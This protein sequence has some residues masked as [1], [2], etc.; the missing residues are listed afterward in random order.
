MPVDFFGS[1]LV[2]IWTKSQASFA[3][4]TTLMESRPGRGM[5]RRWTLLQLSHSHELVLYAV[6][7]GWQIGID[8]ERIQADLASEQ[9]A[10][11]FFSPREVATL[12]ALP[13]DL[14][15]E[16][17]F[18]C[19][20]RKEAYI[21]AHGKGLSLNLQTSMFRWLQESGGAASAVQ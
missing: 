14:R 8:I 9:V 7:N 1:S 5:R 3:S 13:P 4:V 17:F 11:R 18:N 10:E 15:Q 19:W 2:A 12:R 21:K 16:A 20:T 6:T